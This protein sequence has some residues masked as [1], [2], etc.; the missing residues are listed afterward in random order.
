MAE[1]ESRRWYLSPFLGR[2]SHNDTALSVFYIHQCFLVSSNRGL[3]GRF[4]LFYLH[5]FLCT[6]F[7]LDL[8][9]SVTVPSIMT[10]FSAVVASD[11][12]HT[13]TWSLLLLFSV[14]FVVPSFPALRK[15]ELVSDPVGLIIS[16]IFII[17][18]IF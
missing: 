17:R 10:F 11:V 6:L 9:W 18:L 5:E 7:E 2:G 13:S 14:A 12:I 3:V 16:I 8:S 4:L 15:H 1:H